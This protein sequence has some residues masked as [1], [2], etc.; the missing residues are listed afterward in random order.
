MYLKCFDLKTRTVLYIYNFFFVCFEAN[1][2]LVSYLINKGADVNI[3][4]ESGRTSLFIASGLGNWDVVET[5]V[6]ACC[7]FDTRFVV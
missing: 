6:A 1:A 4:D 7:T 2:T 5:V 3:Q